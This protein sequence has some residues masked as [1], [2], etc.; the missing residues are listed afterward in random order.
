[1]K[2]AFSFAQPAAQQPACRGRLAVSLSCVPVLAACADTPLSAIDPASEGARHIANVW[3]VMAWGSAIILLIMVL[4]AA[5]AVSRKQDGNGVTA[6]GRT[7]LMLMGGGVLFPVSVITALLIYVYAAAPAQGEAAVRIQIIGHQ[8]RWDVRYPDVPGGP[9]R[10]VNELHI[11]AG[12]PVGIE[13]QSADVIHSF[14]VPKLGGKMDVIPG[15]TNRMVYVAPEP[16]VYL[17]TCAE[18]CGEGHARMQ[19]TVIAHSR[20]DYDA[21]L[22]ELPSDSGEKP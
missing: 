21:F 8:W 20:E 3:F 7:R 6:A 15:R 14:W 17:A 5:I 9:R 12:V 4:L 19:L 18:Y 1:M 16:D 22:A 2:R 11:P 13:L 10:S